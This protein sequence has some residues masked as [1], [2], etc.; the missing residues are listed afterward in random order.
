MKN[1][2]SITIFLIC[3]LSAV[4]TSCE[5]KPGDADA[6][7]IGKWD[8][9]SL[10]IVNYYDDVRQN[11]T[12]QSYDAGYIV[13]EIFDDG[14]AKKYVNGVI[15]DSFY[16]DVDGELLLMTGNSGIVQTAEFSVSDNN[17]TLMWAIQ[18]TYDSHII[19]SDYMGVYKKQ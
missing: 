19:R 17:L 8:Q 10:K 9:V 3:V 2:L 18:E 15:S 14:T 16:W 7:L 4:I 11:E 1:K 12:D 13:M 6:M 5:K